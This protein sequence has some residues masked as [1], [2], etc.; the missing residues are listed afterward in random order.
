MKNQ[1]ERVVVATCAG[2]VTDEIVYKKTIREAKEVLEKEFG[3]K[4]TK[5][6]W[7]CSECAENED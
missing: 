3:W 2:C 5:E 7:I 6:G 4:K 1:F